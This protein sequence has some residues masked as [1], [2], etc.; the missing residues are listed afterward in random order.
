MSYRTLV[1]ITRIFK[2]HKEFLNIWDNISYIIEFTSYNHRIFATFVAAHIDLLCRLLP[3]TQVILTPKQIANVGIL[4][5]N[6]SHFAANLE[7]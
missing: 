7:N 4:L 5:Y 3:V 1:R 2:K 6:T